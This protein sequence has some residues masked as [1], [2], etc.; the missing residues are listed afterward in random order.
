MEPNG[1]VHNVVLRITSHACD[2]ID[3]YCGT[4]ICYKQPS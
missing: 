1:V 2:V 3:V 4:M